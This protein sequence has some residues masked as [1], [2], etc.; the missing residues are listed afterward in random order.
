MFYSVLEYGQVRLR[1]RERE[2]P[3]VPGHADG[4]RE[5]VSRES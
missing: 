2:E 4:S 3:A 5:V 1:S